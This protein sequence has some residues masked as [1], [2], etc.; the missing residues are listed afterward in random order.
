MKTGKWIRVI[1]VLTII[2]IVVNK[3]LVRRKKN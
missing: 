2:G 1:A 3:V